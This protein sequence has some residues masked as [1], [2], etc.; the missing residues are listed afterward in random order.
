M[1]TILRE[2]PLEGK[3]IILPTNE[4]LQKSIDLIMEQAAENAD[5]QDELKASLDTLMLAV[6]ELM[7][8]NDAPIEEAPKEGEHE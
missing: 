5:K 8:K 2:T 3:S 4:N 7:E 6:A 1:I